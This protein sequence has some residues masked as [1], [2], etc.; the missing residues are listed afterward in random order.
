MGF[1]L[2]CMSALGKATTVIPLIHA[3]IVDKITINIV[4]QSKINWFNWFNC[5][6]CSKIGFQLSVLKP[7]PNKLLIN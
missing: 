3:L 2:P 1:Y 7:K 5:G 4:K 6:T